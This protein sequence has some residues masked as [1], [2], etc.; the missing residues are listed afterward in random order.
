MIDVLR[1][2]HLRIAPQ[3]GNLEVGNCDVHLCFV[4]VLHCVVPLFILGLV[5]DMHPS[6]FIGTWPKR[7]I[8]V[9]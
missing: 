9:R 3:E 5:L 1:I 2:A 7:S 6:L 8:C 4:K